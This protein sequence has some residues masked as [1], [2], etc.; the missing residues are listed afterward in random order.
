[1]IPM[2]VI[3]QQPSKLS[4]DPAGSDLGSGT[5]TDNGAESFA[6]AL[7]GV[8]IEKGEVQQALDRANREESKTKLAVST[9]A[10][11]ALQR[12][13][14][15]GPA[16]VSDSISNSLMSPG[17]LSK[18]M[19]DAVQVDPRNLEER[20]QS[21]KLADA[22]V[23]SFQNGL[24]DVVLEP[25]P[26]DE[27]AGMDD[28]G[29]QGGESLE[30][31]LSEPGVN[32]LEVKSRPANPVGARV[33]DGERTLLNGAKQSTQRVSLE[34][35]SDQGN[36]QLWTL[37][38]RVSTDD[39][40]S[41]R[42]LRKG[43]GVQSETATGSEIA[44]VSGSI[45]SGGQ[46]KNL[47]LGKVIEAPITQGA[48]GQAVLSHDSVH[49]IAH[50]VHLLGQARQDGE[51]KIRLKP[52]HLGE[53]IMNVKSQGQQ[54]SVQIKTHD[55]EAKK[56]IEESLGRL[57]E[58]LSVQNL[59]LS[60]VDVVTQAGAPL[61]SDFSGQMDLGQNGG[62]S[63]GDTSGREDHWRGGRQEFPLD[64]RA[65]PVSLKGLSR[66]SSRGALTAGGLDLIA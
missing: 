11:G 35:R 65:S 55:L 31:L 41:L 63:R 10:G 16:Q 21:E 47:F 32:I 13:V 53:L 14:L 66:P 56:I 36:S 19:P 44:S 34:G 12:T 6:A 30:G 60:K 50:Q 46:D 51:I 24:P 49:Q 29:I 1:M 59:N 37:S 3:P 33:L 57:K 5:S 2:N 58:S 48:S 64:E 54:V 52:D 28:S 26:H 43:K 4:L 9:D 7:Q 62:F 22:K 42:N 27:I 45:S 38:D 15:E 23:S 40:L 25:A 20:I 17:V 39:F 8:G 61:S 18:A